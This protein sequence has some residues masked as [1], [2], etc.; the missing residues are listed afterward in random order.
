MGFCVQE[1]V[2]VDTI[3][4]SNATIRG[5]EGCKNEATT[6]EEQKLGINE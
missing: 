4:A 3:Y 5:S 1:V 2:E 6:N